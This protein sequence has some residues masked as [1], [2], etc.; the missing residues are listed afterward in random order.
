MGNEWSQS[1]SEEQQDGVLSENDSKFAVNSKNGPITQQSKPGVNTFKEN[2][3]A[4][5]KQITREENVI[6]SSQKTI[7]FSPISNGI[8]VNQPPAQSKFSMT[9]SRPTP[10]RATFEANGLDVG[11]G[12]PNMVVSDTP[13]TQASNG[14]AITVQTNTSGTINQA[15]PATQEA[16]LAMSEPNREEAPKPKEINLFQRLFMPEKKVQ[17]EVPVQNEEGG[18]TAE[19]KPGL[20]SAAPAFNLSLENVDESMQEPAQVLSSDTATKRDSGTQTV[21]EGTQTTPTEEVHPI[22]SFF[23]TLVSPNKPVPKSEEEAKNEGEEKK[24]DNGKLRKTSTKKEKSKSF[25]EQTLEAD[26][27]GLKKSDS[28][29]SGTLSRL[30]RQKSKKEEQQASGNKISMQTSK[31]DGKATKETAPRPR[32]FWRKSLKGD[33]QTTKVQDDV[34]E[35]QAVSVSLNAENPSTPEQTLALNPI[36]FEANAQLKDGGKA[37]VAPTPPPKPFWRK[38]FKGDPIPN[39]VEVNSLKE[40]QVSLKQE[41]TVQVPA[42]V[43]VSVNVPP[44]QILIEDPNPKIQTPITAQISND[45][46]K[47][48]KDSTPRPLPF[49]RKSF[50]ADPPP[51]KN[52]E[53]GFQEVA[54]LPVTVISE[55]SA[56]KPIL[57][58]ETNPKAQTQDAEQSLIN[59]EVPVKESTPRP[60]L[61]WKKSFKADAPSIKIQENGIPEPAVVSFSVNAE[62]SVPDR[63]QIQENTVD[64][65]ANTMPTSPDEGKSVKESAARSV[66]F[67]RKE[68]QEPTVASVSINSEKSSPDQIVIQGPNLNIQTQNTEQGSSDDGKPVKEPAA[69]SV[70]FWRKSFKADP[71]PTKIQENSIKED[72]Q[73]IQLTLNASAEPDVQVQKANTDATAAGSGTKTAASQDKA[74]KT[75]DGK[76]A[77]PKLMT[78]F[79]QLSVIGDAGFSKSEEGTS[80][81]ASPP[82]L[83][84]TDGVEVTKSE[85]TVVSAVIETPSPKNKENMKEKKVS[86]EKIAKQDSRESPEATGSIQLQMP[87]ASV[88]VNGSD[89]AR[90]SQLKRTE[91]RQ[92]LGSFF[93]AIGPKRMCDAEVQTDPVSILPAEKVK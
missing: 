21:S 9:I 43:S 82:T 68:I 38:S 58:Q 85:K 76:N 3:Q 59:N 11:G 2:G 77:K 69:P 35:E 93:K 33:P 39:T 62:K 44:Q 88:V 90:E 79:K 49:W 5:S 12:K 64:Q 32:P 30:F 81:S 45:E 18:I 40:D 17:F 13:I 78:F 4:D 63:I 8:N 7:V 72:P 55:K 34:V 61:F 52:E 24:K 26:A 47:N 74:K 1:D 83:D 10:G 53:Y 65:T 19:Q 71:P 37:A 20:Q 41:N 14:N 73:V 25:S 75:E 51:V 16:S 86:A 6:T 27:K 23:K 67:W 84:I 57:I 60:V 28:P 56:P 15:S 46:G 50:K 31:D 54:V 42:A 89:A 48:V 91:K 92:S 29:K 80:Q 36:S 70:P 66:P 87:E 22:M